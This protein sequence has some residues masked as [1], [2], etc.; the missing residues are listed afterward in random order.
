MSTRLIPLFVAAL[1]GC[2]LVAA[3]GLQT[4]YSFDALTYASPK[5]DDAKSGATVPDVACDT[6]ANDVC[7]A[8]AGTLGLTKVTLACDAT[9]KKCVA[10]AEIRASEPIDLSKQMETSFPPQAIEFGVD[11]VEVKRVNYW[12]DDNQLNVATPQIEIYVAPAAARDEHDAKAALLATVA[13][14]PA[15]SKACADPVYAKGDPKAVGVSVCSAPLPEAG[16]A[17]LAA[18]VKDYKTAFQIIAHATIV[19]KPGDPIPSGSINFS[20]R[21]TVGLKILN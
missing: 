4:D 14:L 10:Q 12:I 6:G 5:F 21:P 8:A 2:N 17:A 13:S 3:T 15:K 1:G 7:A 11:V 9:L 19:A 20:A 18:F 16:K